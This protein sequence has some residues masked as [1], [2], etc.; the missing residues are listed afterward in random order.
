MRLPKLNDRP[1]TSL[2]LLSSH[3]VHGTYVLSCRRV[4]DILGSP[5]CRGALQV[6]RFAVLVTKA[7]IPMDFWGSKNNFKVMME[8]T[9]TFISIVLVHRAES[10]TLRCQALHL[11][12]SI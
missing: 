7:V 6:Y 9:S 11:G 10:R 1:S 3:T 4:E 8:R 5:R 12:S 2:A